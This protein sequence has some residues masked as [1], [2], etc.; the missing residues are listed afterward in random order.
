MGFIPLLGQTT[1]A[2]DLAGLDCPAAPNPSGP[3]WRPGFAAGSGHP[4]WSRQARST[5]GGLESVG[6]G[7]TIL[8]GCA[9]TYR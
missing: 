4:L 1:S 5:S 6:R 7:Q 3:R 9:F 2:D 8:A